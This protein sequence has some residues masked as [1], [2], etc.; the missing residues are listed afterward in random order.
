MEPYAT[1]S[2][3]LGVL[4][5]LLVS[6]SP[7]VTGQE[8]LEPVVPILN[9]VVYTAET[10]DPDDPSN[11]SNPLL[12]GILGYSNPNSVAVSLEAGTSVNF[13]DPS[14]AD[15][16]QPTIFEPGLHP[17][18][19][20]VFI[21]PSLFPYVDWNLS[22]FTVRVANNS[23]HYC[24]P[25]TLALAVSGAGTISAAPEV[26][27][28]TDSCSAVV[29]VPA[30]LQLSAVPESGWSFAGYAGDDDCLDGE[31]ALDAG[32]LV[33]CVA[34]FDP[35]VEQTLA[36]VVFGDGV[37]ESD[38]GGIVC[39]PGPCVAAIEDGSIVSLTAYPGVGSDFLGWG[40]DPD[41]T[42]AE[43]TMSANRVCTAT[44]SSTAIFVDG[45]E[46]G[47]SS[48]WAAQP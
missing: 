16:G 31:V 47:D 24:H 12:L 42:D 33:S 27:A 46:S 35:P 13:F 6:A 34:V 15:R 37:V 43:L 8:G 11:D 10:M 4:S 45:F 7:P 2:L 36:I 40:G 28:C 29:D 41:C 18:V 30:V 17:R 25:A 48:A 26:S 20:H 5:T 9:C 19:L 1:R 3:A 14:P 21:N 32:D 39:P 22:G 44:F 23:S 38:V